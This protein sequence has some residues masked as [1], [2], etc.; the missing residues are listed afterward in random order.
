M[1]EIDWWLWERLKD[2]ILSVKGNAI[3][4]CKFSIEFMQICKINKCER[5]IPLVAVSMIV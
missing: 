2:F 3:I 4:L 5:I 1:W